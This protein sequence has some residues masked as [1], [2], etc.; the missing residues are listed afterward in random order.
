MSNNSVIIDYSLLFLSQ[1]FKQQKAAACRY[2][3]SAAFNVVSI[4]LWSR[5]LVKCDNRTFSSPEKSVMWLRGNMLHDEALRFH[6]MM[7]SMSDR[8]R[9]LVLTCKPALREGFT[10]RCGP[11][12]RCGSGCWFSAAGSPHL[13]PDTVTHETYKWLVVNFAAALP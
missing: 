1:N 11:C 4:V 7:R 9:K 3:P 10:H 6:R 5:S 8:Q 2:N 13:Q 12:A